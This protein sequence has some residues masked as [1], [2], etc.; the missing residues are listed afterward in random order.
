MMMVVVVDG[1]ATMMYGSY[2]DGT[3]CAT[4]ALTIIPN[5]T[6]TP[7]TRT[8]RNAKAKAN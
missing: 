8:K 3:S 5:A 4:S 7:C 6:A 1:A 2:G